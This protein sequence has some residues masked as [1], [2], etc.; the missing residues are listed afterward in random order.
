[1]RSIPRIEMHERAHPLNPMGHY[2]MYRLGCAPV[3]GTS[4]SRYGSFHTGFSQDT[5]EEVESYKQN[6][7][8]FSVVLDTN[9]RGFQKQSDI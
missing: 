6:V 8:A 7:E 1:M 5:G 9:L 4:F 3:Q 2:L